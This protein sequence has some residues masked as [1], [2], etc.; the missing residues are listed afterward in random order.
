M[1]FIAKSRDSP[2]PWEHHL[3]PSPW[4]SRRGRNQPCRDRVVPDMINRKATAVPAAQDEGTARRAPH[5][6]AR[7]SSRLAMPNHHD[8]MSALADMSAVG[9]RPGPIDTELLYPRL[10]R[11]ALE[12]QAGGG[13]LRTSQ[14]PVALV[15]RAE[16]RLA[17]RRLERCSA[18]RRREG[19]IAELRH[20]YAK[21]EPRRQDD[22]ALDRVL[23]LP[24]V[25]RPAIP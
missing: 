16:N 7:A 13:P 21:G 2:E 22:G 11:G 10:K 6:E 20:G 24:H 12:T 3:V 4:L 17:L 5:I 19:A 18:G 8:D 23:E 25:S 14:H 9:S 15:Q 1:R